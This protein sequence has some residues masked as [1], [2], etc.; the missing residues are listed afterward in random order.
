MKGEQW[1]QRSHCLS[2]MANNEAGNSAAKVDRWVKRAK[3][4][5]RRRCD[6]DERREW[7]GFDLILATRRKG[8]GMEA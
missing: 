5:E 2:V 8:D 6:A 7:D 3:G 4:N 1:E